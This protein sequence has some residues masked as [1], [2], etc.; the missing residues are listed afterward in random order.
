VQCTELQFSKVLFLTSVTDSG[1]HAGFNIVSYLA[2]TAYE[3]MCVK[4]EVSYFDSISKVLG[5]HFCT[6]NVS[7]EK[8]HHLDSMQAQRL[9]THEGNRA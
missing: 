1:C 5:G 7:Q 2:S 8:Q 4:S 9:S 3:Q 6:Q